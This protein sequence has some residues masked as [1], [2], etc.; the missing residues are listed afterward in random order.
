VVS[1]I[2][3]GPTTTLFRVERGSREEI[4][5]PYAVVG[6]SPRVTTHQFK[7]AAVF[8]CFNGFFDERLGGPQQA[9]LAG[10][11]A[12]FKVVK[13]PK[14]APGRLRCAVVFPFRLWLLGWTPGGLWV[15]ATWALGRVASHARV[16]FPRFP[17]LSVR[18][19][20]PV[21]V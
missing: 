10:C 15:S 9:A 18:G 19:G 21:F 16:F 3:D 14:L 13:M 5:T 12:R 8:P 20:L 2:L 4:P 7:S 6:P 11:L 17:C 1:P